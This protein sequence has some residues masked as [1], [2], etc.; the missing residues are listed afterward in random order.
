M[1]P[2][3][4]IWIERFLSVA[5]LW[6]TFSKDPHTKVGAVIINPRG[7]QL[8]AGFNGIPS[9]VDD[10]LCRMSR[11]DREKDLWMAHA[12]E[13]AITAAAADGVRLQGSTIF[14][15]HFPCPRC[16]GMI[17]GAGIACVV[18]DDTEDAASVDDRA[19]A[20]VYFKLGEARVTLIEHE[21]EAP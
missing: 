11:D 20:A 19:R 3:S 7:R 5:R 1:N 14:S 17:I 9:G 8:S 10:R 4:P 15:T 18:V 16:A 12:E 2:T 6:S 13:N 21:R